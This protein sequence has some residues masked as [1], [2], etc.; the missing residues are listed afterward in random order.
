MNRDSR[1]AFALPKVIDSSSDSTRGT[2]SYFQL[3]E[4]LALKKLAFMFYWS[5][6]YVRFCHI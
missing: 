4:G 5:H 6:K 2:W 3:G 1:I